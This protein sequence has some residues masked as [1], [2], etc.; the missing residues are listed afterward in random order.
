MKKI[1]RS[2]LAWLLVLCMCLSNVSV[3]LV[4]RA[5]EADGNKP[6]TIWRGDEVTAEITAGKDGYTFVSVYRSPACSYEFSNHALISGSDVD[7][8]QLFVLA[9][10][11]KD[12][13]WSPDGR[14]SFGASNYEV[15]YCC[16]AET[17]L[18]DGIYYKRLNLEDSA[19]YDSDSA[20]HIRAILTNSYPYVSLEQMKAN[21][22]EA[23]VEGAENLD[24]AEILSAVQGAV[25][26]FANGAAYEYKMSYNVTKTPTY[27]VPMHDYTAEL[28][29]EVK[30]VIESLGNA[31]GSNANRKELP[32]VG[33]RG[34]AVIKYLMNLEAVYAEKNSIIITDLEIVGA[35]SNT[36]NG[37]YLATVRVNLNNGG[38]SENDNIKLDIYVD[39]VLATSRP[40]Y[41]EITSYDINISAK[42]GQ[43]IKAVVSGTQI[44]PQDVYFYEPEGGRD[45]SQC[46][47][48]I[49][50]GETDVYAESQV[51]LNAKTLVPVDKFATPLNKDFQTTVTLQVPGDVTGA[52]DVIFI[53]GGGMTAN[54]KTID[55]AINVFESSM[56]SGAATVRI[57]IISLEKGQEIIVD[58]NSEEAVLDPD[59]YK[60]FITE[61]F[62]YM[63][64]LPAGTTNL[65]SQLLEAQKM[66]AKETEA[67]ADNK[68]IFVL[69]T[70]RTY[71]FDNENGDQSVVA[72]ETPKVKNAAGKTQHFYAWNDY[73][74]RAIRSGHSSLYMVNAKYKDSWDAYWADVCKWVEA[75]GDKYVYTPGFDK[76][77]IYA[78]SAWAEKNNKEWRE[79]YNGGSGSRYG[80]IIVNPEPTADN[81]VSTGVVDGVT[82][83]T[84]PSNA[85][86]YE[87][88]MYEAAKVYQELVDAG[89]NCYSI[90][91]ET[92]YYQNNS[93]YIANRG[94]TGASTTQLGHSFMNYLARLGGQTEAPAVWSFKYDENGNNTWEEVLNENFFDSIK[95]KLTYTTAA[96]SYVEDY[97]GYDP[98]IGN[99][100]FI[101]DENRIYLTV[102]DVQYVTK[103]TSSEKDGNGNIVKASYSFTKPGNDKATFWLDYDYGNGTTTEMF[104]WTFGENVSLINKLSLEYDLQLIDMT[105]ESGSYWIDTNLS[106]TLYPVIGTVEVG[107]EASACD[108]D[109]NTELVFGDP[110]IFPVPEVQYLVEKL[111]F[112]VT[113]LWDDD[114]DR[115]G[116]R[117]ESVVIKLY[118]NDV[119]V[120]NAT[121]TKDNETA[122]N[123][124]KHIFADVIVYKLPG[125]EVNY[126]IEEVVDED[127]GY[128]ATV[129]GLT[130]T[131]V[132]VPEKVEVSGSK[133]WDDD[134]N[135]D[136]IRPESIT[137][138]LLANGEKV[139]TI[140]VSVEDDWAWSFEGLHKYE[141]GVEIV[142]TITEE[143]VEGYETV[144]DGYNVT[145]VHVPEKVEVSGSKTWDDDNNRDGIRPESITINLLANGEKVQTITVSVEDDWA[146][147]FEGL[148]K[149]EDG[150]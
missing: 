68:Y 65:H 107:E 37:E 100:E 116:I 94:Y 62:E 47:V 11:S 51:V 58:L 61:K 69:A 5:V 40:V 102:G 135:R 113:K 120:R 6:E 16:D 41:R 38:S 84:N 76:S 78:Y 93:P 132:H 83:A 64:T 55:A 99:F 57:G 146:W 96:G 147:S 128:T 32:E 10:A 79:L 15:L 71:W 13:T 133:T 122:T 119:E 108:L 117:P 27:G 85:L 139:Q 23:G 92:A 140:T 18:G 89:Y 50:S 97:I 7:I 74:Y 43:T 143:A 82:Y 73:I 8:P 33:A 17:G 111:D 46:L 127:S 95:A 1:F 70:G 54:R 48:G 77:D 30:S 75:D 52:V 66:L 21:L 110:I 91:S 4:A 87:R 142:Y 36:M 88:A 148:H 22:I 144:I 145:N 115:D 60:D 136:G 14:Y 126:K 134:N 101:N 31:Y 59:T 106:A 2:S 112:E 98:I 39:G 34:N 20:A 28:N 53:L 118:V 45:V 80:N 3:V 24:R 123:T 103:M 81:F 141:D 67:T 9:D 138:N 109:E 42:A 137:I 130:I 56:K 129:D 114:N 149:Y 19:Y 90:C 12:Y 105:T 124:W 44:M 25:W 150:V 104:K 131:N 125:E 63:N 121:L 26:N 35:N 29:P 72:L 86:N 49:A